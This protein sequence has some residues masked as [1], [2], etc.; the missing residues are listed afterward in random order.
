MWS[1]LLGV[2]HGVSEGDAGVLGHRHKLLLL[3]E[4]DPRHLL[5]TLL[6]DLILLGGPGI[7]TYSTG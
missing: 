1:Y 7:Y 3:H 6:I 2:E 5:L 4:V